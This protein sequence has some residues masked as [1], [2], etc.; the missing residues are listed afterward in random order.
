[1]YSSYISEKELLHNIQV[2]VRRC[3]IYVPFVFA[4]R[5]DWNL[6]SR[7]ARSAASIPSAARH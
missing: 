5:T 4:K 2:F 1:M 7:D 3:S 6:V